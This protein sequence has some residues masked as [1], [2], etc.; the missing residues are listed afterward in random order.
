LIVPLNGSL[1]VHL[2]RRGWQE[3]SLARIPIRHITHDG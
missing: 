3:C 1:T 2:F